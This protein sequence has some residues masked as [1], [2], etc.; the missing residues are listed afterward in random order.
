MVSSIRRAARLGSDYGSFTSELPMPTIHCGTY[1]NV[2][3]SSH[4]TSQELTDQG[5]G[6]N[7]SFTM[8]LYKLLKVPNSL[9][10]KK[11]PLLVEIY[12]IGLLGGKRN[13]AAP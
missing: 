7:Q 10:C 4:G 2:Y 9:I 1:N 13:E 5:P 11:R 3:D 6:S 8:T 12:F